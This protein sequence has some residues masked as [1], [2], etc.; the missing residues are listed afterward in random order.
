MI[1]LLHQN[2]GMN[3]KSKHSVKLLIMLMLALTLVISA[4]SSNKGGNTPSPSPSSAAPSSSEPSE[5]PAEEGALP[6]VKDP[7]KLLTWVLT[8]G[9]FRGENY[10][11][12]ISFQKMQ[13][14]TNIEIDWI[15]GSGANGVEA[16]NLLM[17]SGQLPDMVVYNAM[18]SEGPKYGQLGAFADLSKYIDEYA[19]NFKKILDE[20]PDVKRLITTADG[21]I[22]HFPQLNLSEYLLV[23]MFP[24]VRQDWLEKLGLP[25][26]VT[27]DD[28]YN[29][30][31]AFKEQDPNGN[32]KTDEVPFVSVS[33][34]NMMRTFG[35][36]FGTDWEFYVD[37]GKVKFGPNEPEYKDALQYLN[38]LYSEGLIDPN[39]LVDTEFKF[40]TEKVTTDRA[41]AWAGWSGSYMTS[42]TDLMKDH[43]TFEVTGTVPP[44]GPN[45]HQRF[46]YHG[47]PVGSVG[48][49]IS[50]KSNHIVEAVKWLDFQYSEEGIMLNNFGVEG[51]SYEMV[52]G[53]PKFAD[54]VFN[55]PDGLSSTE[56]LL[57]FTIGGGMWATVTDQR[58]QEQYDIE[59]AVDAKNK[60]TALIDYNVALPPF[61]FTAEQNDIIVPLLAD[62]R[63]FRDEYANAYVMGNRSFDTYDEFTAQLK[64]MNID[65][66]LEVYQQ[67]Y[68]E[69]MSRS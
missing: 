13:E 53:Y 9:N 25:E 35:P 20:N 45:G 62:I 49:A 56:S 32:N 52:D 12:K 69:Y 48:I 8:D 66:V 40:L 58:Y 67:A 34:L 60:V 50:A 42:F 15:H 5:Q 4:C 1:I 2:W 26:P 17:A 68:D 63:T 30:L 64:K 7:M 18:N 22:F 37:N 57:N 61:T 51:V 14:L 43:P 44:K 55:S 47:W 21:Q 31:K 6:I 29:M 59:K 24:Q 39:Y 36:A 41:G 10:N 33:L 54:V 23:Q 38:K 28:W 27:T 3:M 16:F 11:E 46:G 65:R 19:P